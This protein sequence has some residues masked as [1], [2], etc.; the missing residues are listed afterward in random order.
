MLRPKF[1]QP[2]DTLIFVLLSVYLLVDAITGFLFQEYGSSFGLSALYKLMVLFLISVRL[3]VLWPKALVFIG[4]LALVL[5]LGP[6]YTWLSVGGSLS[7][8][9]ALLLKLSAPLL[10]F[11]Y[12][13]AL[14]KKEPEAFARGAR[15]IITSCALIL[16]VNFLLG[17]LGFGYTAYQAQPHLPEQALGRKGFFQ[18][19]NELSVVLL[20]LAALLLPLL[21]QRSVLFFVLASLG[22]LGAAQLLMTKTGVLGLGL[23]CSVIPLSAL[24][25][26]LSSR[27][28]ILFFIA[29]IAVATLFFL[30]FYFLVQSG[31]LAD[32]G[33]WQKLKRVYQQQGVLGAI[34]SSR[35]VYGAEIWQLTS[36]H[37]SALH[38][39][40]GVGLVGVSEL[41]WKFWAESDFFDLAMF[42]GVPGVLFAGWIFCGFIGQ[43][44]VSYLK[45]PSVTKSAILTLNV[46]LLGSAIVAGHVLSSG[47]LWPLWALAN[48]WILLQPHRFCGSA[49]NS[50]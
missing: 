26:R 28:K 33:L 30:S 14:I 29:F 49:K 9:V 27:F 18:A 34:L 46:L 36:E 16:G 38:R 44:L 3:S 32:Y 35:D 43:A 11:A 41:T 22:F 50:P 17:A 12:L 5:S 2:L 15:F 1:S 23:L 48:A 40:F 13:T 19:A 47:M 39:F 25:H 24:W 21:W 8:D 20:A 4:L 31:A 45:Q 6:L 42:Y 37:Y 10:A 7:A